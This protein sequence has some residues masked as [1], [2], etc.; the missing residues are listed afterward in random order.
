[1]PTNGVDYLVDWY[2]V[3]GVPRDADT[4]TI[5]AAFR[6]RAKLYHPDRYAHLAP[7]FQTTAEHRVKVFTE[8][9]R[10]LMDAVKRQEFDSTLASWTGSLSKDGT[11][12]MTL[13]K[14]HPSA[15]RL[16]E[17]PGNE[18]MQQ[19]DKQ[20][21]MLS[22]YNESV[23]RIIEQQV[24][25]AKARGEIPSPELVEAYRA[26]L[27][28]KDTYLTVREEALAEVIGMELPESRLLERGEV[29][30]ASLETHRKEIP[31]KLASG[32][33]ALNEQG[34]IRLLG[35]G[36]TE[37]KPDADMLANLQH[38][39]LERFEHHAERLREASLERAKV[40]KKRLAQL[41]IRY[42]PPE[43]DIEPQL[44][45]ILI[46]GED[47]VAFCCVWENGKVQ[48]MNEPPQGLDSIMNWER[49]IPIGWSRIEV[50]LE[51]DLD[52]QEVI[53]EV[54]ER[55]FSRFALSVDDDNDI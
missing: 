24:D 1:M 52:T 2:A 55:H 19:F 31:L 3:L 14:K 26:A 37:T 49:I 33:V 9:H 47:R 28:Q 25:N 16:L 35:P 21:R 22:G 51:P 13:G 17:D 29:I 48:I 42:T 32:L 18:R 23:F 43:Q 54:L 50:T 41:N 30:T 45:L 4:A 15:L 10:I 12:I 27:H 39:A 38:K 11:P 53:G 8:A 36:G 20:A 44:I 6:E 46:L 5:N 40:I 7:E 34:K